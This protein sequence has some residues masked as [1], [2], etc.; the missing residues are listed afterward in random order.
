MRQ[1]YSAALAAIAIFSAFAPSNAFAQSPPTGL[2]ITNYQ[3]V[4][5]QR[6]SATQSNFTYRADLVNTGPARSAITATVTSK[7]P[8]IQVQGLGNLHFAPIGANSQATSLDT[9]TILVD[10]TQP[11]DFSNLQ[12]SFVAPVANAGPNQTA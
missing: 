3:L 11:L 2:S 7:V 1:L 4:S 10:K 8:T 5:E 12:W 9:F 6:V